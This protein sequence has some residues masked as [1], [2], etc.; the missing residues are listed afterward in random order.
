VV[1]REALARSARFAG[2]ASHAVS[3]RPVRDGVKC[4]DCAWRTPGGTCRVAARRV[5]AE[6]PG[7]AAFERALD[8]MTCGACCREAYDAVDVGPRAA[9]RIAASMIERRDGRLYL[10]RAG[11]R[12]AALEG[13]YRCTMYDARPASCRDFE[14]GGRHCLSARR[15]VGLTV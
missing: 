3:G 5:R 4:G 13:H 1:L 6:L 12:C 2:A 10:R 14:R 8:C 11:D 15:K 9:A 7:C